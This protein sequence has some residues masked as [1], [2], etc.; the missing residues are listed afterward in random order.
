MN[1]IVYKNHI[2]TDHEIESGSIHLTISLTSA[3]LEA[4][5]FT[6]VVRS[7]DSTLSNF[8][9]NTQ[10]TFYRDER[11][12]CIVYVQSI[13]RIA[14]DRY[15]I[16][17]TSAVGLLIEGQHMGGIY[18]GQTAGEII[19]DICGT[20][21]F[22]V[23]TNLIDTK[24]YGWL[25]IASPRDN[26][27]QVLFAIGAALK[28]DLDGVLRVENLWDGISS[29]TGSDRMYT[30]A[31][32]DYDSKVTQ[33]IVTEHQYVPFTEEKQLF[34][35]TAQQGDII[36]FDA[37]MHDLVADGFTIL[38]SG[39]NWAK[40]SAGPGVL[41]GKTYIHNTRQ[42]VKDVFQS[43][44]PNVKSVK[45]ATLVSLVNSLACAKRLA[46]YYKCRELVDA[47]VVYNGELP[48]DLVDTYHPF[49][50][51]GVSA[52]LESADITMSNQL[53]A[54]VKLRAGY[55]PPQPESGEYYD[56]RQLLTGSGHFLVPEGVST[57]RY[58]LI[59]AGQGG[60][61]GRPGEA[62]SAVSLSFTNQIFTTSVSYRG[63]GYG[64]G[65][66][67][68]VG[69]EPGHGGRVLEGELAVTPGQVIPWNCG[70]GG[71]GAVYDPDNLDAEGQEGGHT[72]F[73]PVSSAAGAYTQAGWTDVT[74]GEI[75]GTQGLPGIAGGRGAGRPEDYSTAN[76]DQVRRV[77]QAESVTDED[78]NV[79]D[80]GYTRLRSDGGIDGGGESAKIAIDMDS[81]YVTAE[82]SCNLGSGAAAG[83]AGQPGYTVPT[84]HYQA[85]K[86]NGELYGI[87]SA[88]RGLAGADALLVPRKATGAN[89]GRGG[90]GGGGGSSISLAVV[91]RAGSGTIHVTTSSADPG[92]GGRGSDGG[93]GGDG[94]IILFY[95][96]KRV[97]PSGPLVTSDSAW[98]LD[99][100][101]RRFIT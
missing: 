9:R 37:P 19:S 40:V 101:G 95:S 44:Y 92:P 73:G 80:G 53:K 7:D 20:V 76:W 18:T 70:V 67:G 13:D 21:P 49:D 78:G 69:G 51:N 96:A 32:V 30:D 28:T 77:A 62:G 31:S 86:R 88:L 1:K 8:E 91:G 47:P 61:C 56:T 25:P 64:P 33:V 65:G 79:W 97:V 12:V 100:L 72:T 27:S 11:Q 48:G 84:G 6:S 83:A 85:Y 74:T 98:F 66:A 59:Q 29:T 22:I 52:C 93:Q 57:V 60:K 87:A 23:K 90:Y 43:Q 2:F 34:D 82:V 38:D 35:G 10:M 24:L 75:Y 36:T 26:L 42:I 50:K 17:A 71:L 68:G 3:Q 14:A 41:T 55:T 45:D 99:S 46:E 94:L 63:Y 15:K 58:V 5:T 81:G 89:G 16:Y 39:A 54:L 4:N